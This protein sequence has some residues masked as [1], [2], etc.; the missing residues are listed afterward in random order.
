MRLLPA[1]HFFLGIVL[2]VSA[3]RNGLRPAIHSSFLLDISFC[4]SVAAFIQLPLWL[5]CR[6]SSA[7]RES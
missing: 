5:G 7:P 3:L 2:L 4:F 1:F 6:K